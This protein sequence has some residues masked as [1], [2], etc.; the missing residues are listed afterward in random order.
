MNNYI[1]IDCEGDGIYRKHNQQIFK[2]G[3]HF[4]PNTIVWCVTFTS[5]KHSMTFFKKLPNYTNR[6]AIIGESGCVIGRV[7]SYHEDWVQPYDWSNLTFFNNYSNNSYRDYLIA[8][9]NL[10]EDA[11]KHNYTIYYKSY[12]TYEYDKDLLRVNFERNNVETECLECMKGINIEIPETHQQHKPGDYVPNEQFM[13]DG[14][15][16]NIEDSKALYEAL[17]DRHTD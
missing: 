7:R 13:N 15:K 11:N 6:R 8:I 5:S 3:N 4:D 1:T 16:H 17:Y 9:K 12:S 14:I 2:T 10:I